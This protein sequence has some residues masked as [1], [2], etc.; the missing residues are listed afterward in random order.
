MINDS[1]FSGIRRLG[2]AVSGGA[3]STALARLVAPWC[4]RHNIEVRVLHVNH[5]WRGE[6]SDADEAFTLELARELGIPCHVKHLAKNETRVPGL[7]PEMAARNARQN[8]FNES[9]AAWQL[10][11]IATGHHAGD[12]A[13]TLLLRLFR[14]AGASG[15]A[16]LRPRVEINGTT[17]LRP[18]LSLQPETLREWLRAN[19]HPWR[20]DSTNADNTIPRNLVR[21][22][23]LPFLSETLG[24]DVT[25]ALCQSADIL[26][27]EDALLQ[28]RRH[29]C[30]RRMA[31]PTSQTGMSTLLSLPRALQ[32]R[33]VRDFLLTHAGADAA[34]FAVVERILALLSKPRWRLA[35][36]GGEIIC[37][38]ETLR[39]RAFEVSN[40][41]EPPPVLLRLPD[42]GATA[43]AVWNNI[44]V[45][46]CRAP[47]IVRERFAVGEL[48]ARASFSA[49]ALAGRDITIR[50]W[51][52]GDRIQQ[53][54]MAG[55]RKLQDI[56]TDAKI[57][58]WRRHEIPVFCCGDEIFWLPGCRP[59][60]AFAVV[61]ERGA[62]HVALH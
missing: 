24:R 29:S 58:A 14:G 43:E 35:V 5:G 25:R 42:D 30:L 54:G 47:G 60:S 39:F 19:H 17:Y 18:L 32:R 1:L 33:A 12:V 36:T 20:E 21:N 7:S 51:R 15:L 55:R 4:A 34:G 59:A 48:P 26:G 37:E 61:D 23:V 52:D 38:N 46:L 11:A 31:C 45:T 22:R 41:R 49:D 3:D 9:R 6:D 10:D 57:P 16:G 13:E 50:A 27:E 40:P 2:L 8:F 62:A 28:E 53:L 44:R 56:F